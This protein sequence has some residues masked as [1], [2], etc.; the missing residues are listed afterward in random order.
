MEA[1][2]L[3]TVVHFYRVDS[4]LNPVPVQGAAERLSFQGRV[5]G[6]K[7]AE[8]VLSEGHQSAWVARG[9]LVPTRDLCVSN[10]ELAAEYKV[11]ED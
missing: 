2:T 4:L 11:L 3:I 8:V 7:K 10:S 5:K 9:I 1:S 6:K